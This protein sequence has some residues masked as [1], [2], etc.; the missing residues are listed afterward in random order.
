MKTPTNHRLI[1][2]RKRSLGQGNILTGVC[3]SIGGG[4]FPDS[5]RDTR[6]DTL[7]GQRPPWTETPLD[8]DPSAPLDRGP[9][10][11][12]H[13]GQRPPGQGPPSV[14]LNRD[15]LDRDPLYGKER[16]VSIL[17]ECVLVNILFL[18]LGDLL[19]FVVEINN[20]EPHIYRSLNKLFTIC[21]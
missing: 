2:P 9:P 8:R 19:D 16:A 10:G 4:G 20:R 7:P 12:R 1:T 18:V 11:Q 5:D 13:R 15:P 21:F 3:L 6:T 17:L 14:P